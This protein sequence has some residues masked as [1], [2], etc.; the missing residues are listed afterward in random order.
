MDTVYELKWGY[1]INVYDG[2]YPTSNVIIS[3][4]WK[5]LNFELFCKY[6]WYF[7]YR[8]AL[9]R[10]LYPKV[11]IRH[12]MFK[13]EL[14]K[15]ELINHIKNKIIGKKRTITKYKNRLND[16][17]NNWNSLFPISDYEPYIKAVEKIERL[18]KELIEL[19]NYE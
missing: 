3:F 5:D 13:R 4:V 6:K 14:N 19:E 2:K 12:E 18:K 7:E 10:V 11:L 9:L 8:Y 1:Y 16:F 15:K 17:E